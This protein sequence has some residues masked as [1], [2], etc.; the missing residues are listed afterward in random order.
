MNFDQSAFLNNSPDLIK[1]RKSQ[2]TLIITGMGVLLF[3]IWNVIKT[4]GIIFL[5]RA[6]VIQALKD[7]LE[8]TSED[9]VDMTDNILFFVF[10]FI[11]ALYLSFGVITRT[12]VGFS[13][14]SEGKKYRHRKLY[15]V[16]CFLLIF[17]SMSDIVNTLLYYNDETLDLFNLEAENSAIV[18]IIIEI[19]SIIIIIEMLVAAFR[20][21]YFQ[22]NLQQLK[23]MQASDNNN[24]AD[25][26]EDT[27]MVADKTETL[28]ITSSKA[29]TPAID[30][31][32]IEKIETKID[33]LKKSELIVK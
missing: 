4:M 21:R 30:E 23:E 11:M 25:N 6:V 32:E 19:T 1:M 3:G 18:S 9:L 8:L 2:N 20:V 14:I 33:D 7:Q 27:N 15:L 13:A 16:V 24:T 12:I 5:N 22:N 31:K 29:D 28:N 17:G 26:A 10:L